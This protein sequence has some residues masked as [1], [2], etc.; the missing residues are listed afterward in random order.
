MYMFCGCEYVLKPLLSTCSYIFVWMVEASRKST[1]ETWRSEARLPQHLDRE[2]S[3]EQQCCYTHAQYVHKD[4]SKAV[5]MH[6][7]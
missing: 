2:W 3:P 6:R 5:A 7:L 4:L 1:N